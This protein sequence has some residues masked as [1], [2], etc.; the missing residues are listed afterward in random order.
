MSVHCDGTKIKTKMV[1]L[2]HAEHMSE[3][4]LFPR[5]LLMCMALAQVVSGSAL[6]LN[7]S[8]HTLDN[9]VDDING[10][11]GVIKLMPESD[12]NDPA[13][14]HTVFTNI[15]RCPAASNSDTCYRAELATLQ[16]LRPL[17]FPN[18]SLEYWLG[19][20]S[21]IPADWNYDENGDSL[22]YNFQLHGI[23]LLLTL[24]L[25][26]LQLPMHLPF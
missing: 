26:A 2:R 14:S 8:F 9:W 7:E 13:I 16:A 3:T 5:L 23:N 15:T 17:L 10:D 24:N 6:L 19:F 18:C 11:T 20:S 12:A 25:L 21:I 1:Q 4:L 22:V